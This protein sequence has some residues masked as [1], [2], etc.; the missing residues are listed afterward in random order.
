MTE[1]L[2]IVILSPNARTATI[3]VRSFEL[4]IRLKDVFLNPFPGIHNN[5]RLLSHLLVHFSSL[6]LK[7]Y[8]PRSD[9]SDCSL[10]SSLIRV[11][12]V[13]YHG[14]VCFVALRPKSTAMVMEGRSVHLTTFFPVQAWI[15][16][17]SCTYFRCYHGKSILK[18]IRI[19]A[20]D[21]ISRH[22][23][24]QKYIGIFFCH[25]MSYLYF[26]C[27]PLTTV[28]PEIF[29]RIYFCE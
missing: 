11:H 26:K 8:G 10:R 29:M 6:F 16:S 24:Y 17:T 21:A 9:C 2:L 15:T 20:A 14:F 4:R 3:S 23:Q 7:H 5:C 13:C 12:S 22:F 27:P 1:K 18:C 25:V 19:Y 28:N